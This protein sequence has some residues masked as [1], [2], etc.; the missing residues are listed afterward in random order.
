MTATISSEIQL[1]APTAMIELFVVDLT[2]RSG[3]M[4]YFHNGTNGLNQ[5]IVW[6]GQTYVHMPIQ[7]KGFEKRASGT[8]PRPTVSISNVN[9]IMGAQARDY[10]DFLGCKF[11]RRRTF[12]RFLDA[13]NFPTGNPQAD[14]SQAF[15][16]E[17]WF[18]DRKSIEN[19]ATLEFELSSAL[20]L[21]GVML[22]R[23][24]IIQN[25]CA[26]RYR[27]AECGYAGGPVGKSDDTPTSDPALDQCSKS[28]TG[29]K[30]RFSDVLPFGGFPGCGLTR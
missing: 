15:P 8:L 29:C 1:L 13:V 26:W 10:G 28:L 20:D 24:Q 4:L 9:G 6:K 17:V 5:N 23:R 25:T 16:D 21:N 22:P 14:P 27:S 30:M 12:V 18:F 11:I 7:A 3:G 19:L 2:K